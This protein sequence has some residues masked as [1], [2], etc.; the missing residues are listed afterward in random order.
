[1]SKSSRKSTQSA[2]AE[3]A[4][5]GFIYAAGAILAISYPV[6]ALSTGVRAI[7][8][9]VEGDPGNAPWLT[10]L[11]ALFYTIATIGFAK[12]PRPAAKKPKPPSQTAVARAWR[13]LS[14]ATAWRISLGTLAVETLLT[15]VVGSLSY[16][17]PD[18]IGRNV[19]QFF[20]RDYGYFPLIQPLLGL[21]WLLHPQTLRAYGI[22]AESGE[23]GA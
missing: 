21:A 11:A 13:A 10:L 19:W 20:G 8:Q 12:Q 4:L 6:L 22:R 18:V 1:M 15:L 23:R 3:G 17:A 16:L 5:A 9:I 2:D 14:P 7:Y